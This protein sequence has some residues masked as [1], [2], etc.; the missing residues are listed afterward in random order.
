MSIAATKGPR[1]FSGPLPEKKTFRA[2][3]S[4]TWKAGELCALT[5]TGKV[6]AIGTAGVKL[7]GVF[8]DSQ[9]TSTSTTD[10]KVFVI[11][12]AETELVGYVS[13]GGNDTTAQTTHLG[14]NAGVWSASNVQTI[15]VGNDTTVLF[16]I[17]GRL[18]DVEPYKNATTD[19]P[20]QLIVKVIDASY[21]QG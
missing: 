13:N 4:Q 15:N 1:Y 8:A 3:D 12:S 5:G 9:S 2:V 19:S 7:L 17:T 14:E 20:G 16:R 18:V 10:V 21:L 6:K 11:T